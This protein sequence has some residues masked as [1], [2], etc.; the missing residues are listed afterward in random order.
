M[1]FFEIQSFLNRVMSGVKVTI[2]KIRRITK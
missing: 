2:N 1:K